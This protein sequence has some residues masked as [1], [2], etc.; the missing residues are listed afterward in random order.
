MAPVTM[1][2]EHL[3]VFYVFILTTLY[4]AVQGYPRCTDGEWR[5]W[6]TVIYPRPHRKSVAEPL[7]EPVFPDSQNALPSL[8][9]M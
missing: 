9:P 6:E 4:E 7:L 3:R 1:V 8:F 5:H 2:P